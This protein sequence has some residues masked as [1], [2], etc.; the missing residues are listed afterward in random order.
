MSYSVGM[1]LDRGHLSRKKRN[2]SLIGFS[3][4]DVF[5]YSWNDKKNTP[6]YRVTAVK[7]NG[8]WIVDKNPIGMD[9]VLYWGFLNK[10]SV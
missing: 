1:R 8:E 2:E 3:Y 4:E 6:I 7:Q 10:T 9:L 5:K